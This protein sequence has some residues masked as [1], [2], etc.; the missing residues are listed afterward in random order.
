MNS[1]EPDRLTASANLQKIRMLSANI[2]TEIATANETDGVLIQSD[3]QVTGEI[4]RG[5]PKAFRIR[6]DLFVNFFR[7]GEE[8]SSSPVV[9]IE[10]S[11]ELLY[12]VELN[13]GPGISENE[14]NLFGEGTAL[15]NV[16]PYFREFVQSSLCRMDLPP[17]SL[18]LLRR[19]PVMEDSLPEEKRRA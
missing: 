17:I 18:P 8:D 13:E 15:F 10:A 1:Q 12:R 9:W 3:R 5:E 4:D 16:W 2:G 7:E 11:Y 19:R 6:I 14:L